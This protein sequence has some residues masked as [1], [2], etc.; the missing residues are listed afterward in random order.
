M[1]PS[2]RGRPL[3]IAPSAAIWLMCQ[4]RS[5]RRRPVVLAAGPHLRHARAELNAVAELYPG[6][7]TLHGRAADVGSVLRAIDGASIAH[8][9]CHGRMRSDSPLFSSL[10]LADGPLNVYELQHLRRPPE[11]VVLSSCDLAT[12][13]THPGDELLG[14]AAALLNMGT[15]TVIASTV[16]VPDAAAKRLMRA[17]HEQLAARQPPARAL[18]HAQRLIATGESALTG[19]V[20]LGSG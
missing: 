5:Y 14:F 4:G 15:R 13:A 12:S 1:L 20:C 2:L 16:P 11:L 19:F 8:L 17:L 3:T 6:A 18:A 9:A 10:E 7:I